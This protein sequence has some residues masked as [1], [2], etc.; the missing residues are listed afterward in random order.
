MSFLFELVGKLMKPDAVTEVDN[1]NSNP[2]PNFIDHTVQISEMIKS[3]INS[4]P[5]PNPNLD[6]VKSD[7]SDENGTGILVANPGSIPSPNPNSNPG[8][9]T[10]VESSTSTDKSDEND[11]GILVE[12]IISNDKNENKNDDMKDEKN[13]ENSIDILVEVKVVNDKKDDKNNEKCDKK[14]DEKDNEIVIE[15]LIEGVVKKEKYDEKVMECRLINFKV[16]IDS[17]SDYFVKYP[18]RPGKQMCVYK[19]QIDI[20]H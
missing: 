14:E 9:Y 18:I 15:S 6:I 13:N 11:M 8:A 5:N 4:N 3:T 2:N 17:L 1:S 19:I 20:D 10:T 7:K 12:R 16:S